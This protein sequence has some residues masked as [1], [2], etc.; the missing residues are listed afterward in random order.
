MMAR[1]IRIVVIA[2]SGAVLAAITVAVFFT[3][4][5]LLTLPTTTIQSYL[6]RKLPPGTTK[7]DVFTFAQTHDVRVSADVRTSGVRLLRLHLGT[8]RL[9]FRTDVIAFIR[10][11]SGNR[12]LGIE[13]RKDTDSL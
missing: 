5:T 1:G 11:D 2:T 3:R 9:I 4:S 13:V 6:L 12:V 10:L 8:Y 7:N